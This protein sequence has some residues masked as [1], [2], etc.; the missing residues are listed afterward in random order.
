MYLIEDKLMRLLLEERSEDPLIMLV[1][2]VVGDHRALFAA[3]RHSDEWSGGTIQDVIATRE[4][5]LEPSDRQ[6]WRGHKHI[7]PFEIRVVGDWSHI[8]GIEH[9]AAH[10]IRHRR[11]VRSDEAPLASA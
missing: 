4:T 2:P 3:A 10:K 11:G 8:L 1:D 6:H 5:A 9:Y 7:L